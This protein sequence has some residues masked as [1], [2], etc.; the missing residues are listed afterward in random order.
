MYIYYVLFP[1]TQKM[2]YL[3]LEEEASVKSLEEMF[4]GFS[5]KIEIY[6]GLCN[7]GLFDLIYKN[8]KK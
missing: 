6:A 4:E 3:E 8:F 5:E 7:W 1:D 2:Q